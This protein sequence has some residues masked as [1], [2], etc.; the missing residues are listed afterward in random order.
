MHVH[1]YSSDGEAKFW[2]EPEIA[3]A[4]KH[5]LSG[6]Q[7][8]VVQSIVTTRHREL[9]RAWREYFSSNSD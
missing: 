6:E 4:S 1:I 5:R 7:L 9:S 8:A 3:L 2:L